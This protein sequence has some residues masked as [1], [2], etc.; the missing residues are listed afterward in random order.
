M[1]ADRCI[2]GGYGISVALN[3]FKK[4]Q[5]EGCVSTMFAATTIEQSGQYI[6]PPAANEPGS[7]L[8][9]DAM[10]GEQLMKLT[11]EVITEKTKS[12]SADKGCPMKDY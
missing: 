6:C 5:F 1:I 4:D 2:V 10:L 8:S 12:E 11:R 7:G 3:P 9:R